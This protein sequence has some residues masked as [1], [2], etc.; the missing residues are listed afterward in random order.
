MLALEGRGAPTP[1]NSAPRASAISSCSSSTREA[2]A[3]RRH[4]GQGRVRARLRRAIRKRPRP[5]SSPACTTTRRISGT[6]RSRVH[7]NTARRRR[8]RGAGRRQPERPSHLSVGL[9]R[10]AR[11][12]GD[13]GRHHHQD[14][15][16]RHPGDDARG[17]PRSFRHRAAGHR[18]RR[19]A[20]GT[21][22]CGARPRR[23]APS[24]CCE[25]RIC[26]PARAWDAS[27]SVPTPRWA[28]RWHSSGFER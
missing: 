4:A 19:A 3:P 11:S 14:A 18:E 13:L 1:T 10:R 27:S 8:R 24:G 21:A 22:L 2:Q 7:A 28:R 17:I 5:A 25:W 9:H 12:A 26:P 15:A 20:R 16:R 6:R 23:T